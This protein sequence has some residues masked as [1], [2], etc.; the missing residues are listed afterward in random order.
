MA[1]GYQVFI[2]NNKFAV[3]AEIGF[4]LRPQFAKDICADF[5]PVTFCRRG[6]NF[7]LML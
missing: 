7:N 2:G 4:N 6:R 1:G 5:Y 3:P